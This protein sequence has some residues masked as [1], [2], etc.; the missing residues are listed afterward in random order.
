MTYFFLLL[1]RRCFENSK[2]YGIILKERKMNEF[3]GK[4]HF[5]V[6][7]NGKIAESHCPSGYCIKKK[8]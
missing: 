3:F 8:V 7:V 1:N 5:E 6:V 2:N 4:V